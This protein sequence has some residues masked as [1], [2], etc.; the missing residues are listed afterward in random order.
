MSTQ[1]KATPLKID[2]LKG[3]FGEEDITP[4][5]KLLSVDNNNINDLS[6]VKFGEKINIDDATS[7]GFVASVMAFKEKTPQ[8]KPKDIAIAIV[9]NKLFH[10][11]TA[12]I[13]QE[14][15]DHV[16]LAANNLYLSL[17]LILNLESV[18]VEKNNML[19]YVN[20]APGAP[21]GSQATKGAPAIA[22]QP[23]SRLQKYLSPHANPTDPF[24]D[25][26]NTIENAN[27]QILQI[28]E[29][30]TENGKLKIDETNANVVVKNVYEQVKIAYT[31]AVDAHNVTQNSMID[32]I[33]MQMYVNQI[34]QE[35]NT[36]NSSYKPIN[37]FGYQLQGVEVKLTEAKTI[38]NTQKDKDTIVKVILQLVDLIPEIRFIVNQES[39]AE[40]Q[41]YSNNRS[42][43]LKNL[44]SFRGRGGGRNIIL[45]GQKKQFRVYLDAQGRKYIKYKTQTYLTSIRGKF[46]YV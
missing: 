14:Y 27:N 35:K 23:S 22:H 28:L 15:I 24:Q 32:S 30:V 16:K 3:L 21:P 6:T 1:G 4:A 13:N 9:L 45:N 26:K 40:L 18:M 31:A 19:V 12:D 34:K 33:S 20:K 11:K 39:R 42:A 17:L 46:K 29:S 8:T 5:L 10:G 37:D 43:Q 25:A 7:E 2:A 36:I 44:P 41:A 38:I